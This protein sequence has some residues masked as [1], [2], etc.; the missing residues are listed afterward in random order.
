MNHKRIK[1]IWDSIGK[2]FKSISVTIHWNIGYQLEKKLNLNDETCNLINCHENFI[3]K[4]IWT[5]QMLWIIN[6]F[7][8]IKVMLRLKK[9]SIQK[10]KKKIHKKTID[11]QSVPI[12]FSQSHPIHSMNEFIESITIYRI[13]SIFF[14]WITCAV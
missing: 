6:T 2:P 10:G 3:D 7:I 4:I 1:Q 11:M 5:I 13:F 12:K 8:Y 14:L 9:R